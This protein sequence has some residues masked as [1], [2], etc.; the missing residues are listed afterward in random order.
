MVAFVLIAVPAI[1]IFG[2]LGL[3]FKNP[4]AWLLGKIIFEFKEYERA[5]VYR[6]GKFHRTVGAGWQF[7]IP[8]IDSFQK[9]DLRTEAIDVPPQEVI[10]KDGV[11]LFIDA[12]MYIKIDDP[13]KAEL[14]VEEDYRKAVEEYVKGRIRN[15]IGSMELINLYAKIGEINEILKNEVQEITK[16]WGV[17]IMDVELVNVNPP[18]EVIAA[19]EAEEI[20][21]R[22]KDAEL[23]KAKGIQ[24][25]LNAIKESAG[26][27]NEQA[28]AYLYMDTMKEM[29]HGSANKIIFPLELTKAMENISSVLGKKPEVVEELT[30][31]LSK[32]S[33]Q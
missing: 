31:N 1:L 29:A 33:D 20:A 8:I 12:V 11:K 24:H 18:K 30:K 22:Y 14:N 32:G 5:V 25:H 6:F 2:G 19:M 15:V 3:L 10:T 17:N 16:D 23:E 9:Y 21:K 28:L 7:L 27:L 4:Q 26:Q 13:V